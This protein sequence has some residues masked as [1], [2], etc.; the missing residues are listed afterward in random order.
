[1]STAQAAPATGYTYYI[2]TYDTVSSSG[3]PFSVKLTYTRALSDAVCSDRLEKIELVATGPGTVQ[4]AMGGNAIVSLD[5]VG[6]FTVPVKIPKSASSGTVLGTLS[7]FRAVS[8]NRGHSATPTVNMGITV[9]LSDTSLILK[10]RHGSYSGTSSLGSFTIAF[11]PSVPAKP[12][13]SVTY[14]ANGGTGAPGAQTKWYGESLTL[15]SGRPTRAGHYFKGWATSASGAAA[16]QPGA[17][18]TGN[19]ALAL[20]AVWEPY[21]SVTYSNGGVACSGMP[22]AQT[23]NKDAALALSPSVPTVADR[24]R[25]FLGWAASP[26]GPVAYLP[27]DSYTGN[28]ALSLHAVWRLEWAGA[29]SEL[30]VERVDEGGAPDDAGDYALVCGRLAVQGAMSIEAQVAVIL[31]DGSEAP[32]GNVSG[33]IVEKPAG[34]DAAAAEFRWLS[35]DSGVSYQPDVQA[36]FKSSLRLFEIAGAEGGGSCEPLAEIAGPST[37]LTRDE[38]AMDFHSSGHGLG[39]F[40]TS[41]SKGI[42]V[43]EALDFWSDFFPPGFI[44]LSSLPTSPAERFGGVW[45]EIKN[46]GFLRL[47]GN[48]LAGGS[49]SRTLTT[50]NLPSHSHYVPAHGHP[51]NSVN[52][53][54]QSGGHYHYTAGASSYQA[55]RMNNASDTTGAD[56][57][58][59]NLSGSGHKVFRRLE[60][61]GLGYSRDTGSGLS[62]SHHHAVTTSVRDRARFATE[63]TG[64]GT[65][66]DI[67]PKYQNVYAWRR[68]TPEEEAAM[69]AAS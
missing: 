54:N 1:M 9:R 30:S 46:E 28:A 48:F 20:Y 23:K 21:W 33:G 11:P 60:T 49:N 7:V 55:A 19:A 45:I 25:T 58:N 17:T 63:N 8:S 32:L 41:P 16:Y 15:Q 5:T 62:A 29:I 10:C 53:G 40:A 26:G 22:S 66:I 39:I 13:Y 67:T 31:P 69:A 56:V 51:G 6:N 65:A 14:S 4:T 27:G 3:I 52:T 2:S 61:T 57:Y 36:L 68:A 47:A 34:E 35:A 50:A 37:I 12:S 44:Y 18:Y 43:G 24:S 38:F 64:S 59:G 42:R